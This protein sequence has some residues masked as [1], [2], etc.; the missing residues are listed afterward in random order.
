MDSF[1]FD[2][3]FWKISPRSRLNQFKSSSEPIVPSCTFYTALDYEIVKQQD[4]FVVNVM[5]RNS[6][7][8]FFFDRLPNTKD[9]YNLK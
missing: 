8:K 2:E 1:S 4:F 7:F 9:D 3:L 5:V 6:F